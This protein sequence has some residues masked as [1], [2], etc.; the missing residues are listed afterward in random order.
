MEANEHNEVTASNVDK[1]VTIEARSGGR[2][3]RGIIAPLYEAAKKKV[4]GR[5]VSLE[6]AE[7][8]LG[9]VKSGDTVV[10]VCGMAGMPMVPFGETDGPS[11]T[12]S[13]ARAVRLGLGGIPVLVT[14]SLDIV[15]LCAA[16]KAAGLNIMGYED[17]QKTKSSVAVSVIFPN[18]DA[19]ESRKFAASLM[20]KYNPKAVVSVETVGPNKK[21]YKHYSSG[22]PF[23]MLVKSV[24]IEHLFYEASE[25][26]VLTIGVIDQGNE[27]GSGTIEETVRELVPYG[28]VCQC[29]C[30][31]G[32]VC[33]VKT[34][35][36]F[37]AAISNWGAYAI[38]AMLG[39]LLNKPGILQD[40]DTER[41]MIEASIMAGAVD[42][43]LGQ[44]IVS[45]DGINGKTQEAFITMLHTIIE[46]ALS[47]AGVSGQTKK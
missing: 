11:G 27:I 22:I 20:D 2:Q 41:R 31:G 30:K 7:R 45:V 14:N 47:G 32:M 25:R 5:P 8:L 12:A 44:A 15:P 3:D 13:L 24:G 34:D 17:C 36:T 38:V 1:M 29:E 26:G 10:L 18:T 43:V 35:V 23:E 46:N 19:E 21:G 4:G 33:A 16:V 28:D 39:L 40:E 37:P 9:A 6:A 42:G